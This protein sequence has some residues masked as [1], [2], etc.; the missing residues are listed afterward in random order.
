MDCALENACVS[1]VTSTDRDVL[2]T[3]KWKDQAA[4]FFGF[5]QM[6]GYNRYDISGNPNGKPQIVQFLDILEKLDK[7]WK[8][9]KMVKGMRE[10]KRKPITKTRPA[11]VT[12]LDQILPYGKDS[13]VEAEIAHEYLPFSMARLDLGTCDAVTAEME[14]VCGVV[15][16][17]PNNQGCTCWI[18]MPT[19]KSNSRLIRL[20]GYVAALVKVPSRVTTF[21]EMAL[22]SGKNG[23]EHVKPLRS[24]EGTSFKL[25]TCDLG[26]EACNTEF[27]FPAG[28]KLKLF[29]GA[30]ATVSDVQELMRGM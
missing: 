22:S 4:L 13:R 16:E 26:E 23:T 6:A 7:G 25:A 29:R 8:P 17:L 24:L 15:V 12:H 28:S 27:A 3:L 20:L 2:P 11:Y 5:F 30:P 10:L 21:I 1:G 18:N 14:H 9:P 19:F